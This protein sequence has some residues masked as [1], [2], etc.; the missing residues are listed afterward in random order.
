LQQNSLNQYQ[1]FTKDEPTPKRFPK[2]RVRA[3]AVGRH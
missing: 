3:Y 2:T 1:Y